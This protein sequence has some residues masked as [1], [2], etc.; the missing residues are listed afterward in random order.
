MVTE[1]QEG[2]LIGQK[3]ILQSEVARPFELIKETADRLV[4]VIKGAGLDLADLP[5]L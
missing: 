3:D 2:Q 1:F 4:V 5:G